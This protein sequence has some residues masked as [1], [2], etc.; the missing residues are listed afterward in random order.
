MSSFSPGRSWWC[1]QRGI[2][3][4]RRAKRRRR[5]LQASISRRQQCSRGWIRRAKRRSE[6]AMDGCKTNR[7]ECVRWSRST[8]AVPKSGRRRTGRPPPTP[9]PQRRRSTRANEGGR[10]A[11]RSPSGSCR[12]KEA[13]SADRVRKDRSTDA[14]APVRNRERRASR[15]ARRGRGC[16]R[17]AR[18][19]EH[20]TTAASFPRGTSTLPM[21]NVMNAASSSLRPGYSS[22]IRHSWTN[23]AANQDGKGKPVAAVSEPPR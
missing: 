4:T 23:A 7:T 9:C 20:D 12:R 22:R 18:W 2:A 5:L 11:L 13:G 19:R 16:G 21:P 15:L 1:E 10:P 6:A 17:G 8:P 3:N 14:R